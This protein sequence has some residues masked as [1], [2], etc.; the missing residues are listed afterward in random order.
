VLRGIRGVAIATAAHTRRPGRKAGAGD[1]LRTRYLDLGK[2]AL[3]QVSYSR[4]ARGSI[5]P[6]GAEPAN[7][8]PR[9]ARQ[10][11]TRRPQRSRIAFTRIAD[12]WRR[13]RSSRP[14]C[15]AERTASTAADS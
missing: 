8:A 6:G 5:L 13:A 10:G 12:S 4:S 9:G 14:D 15:T 2:V 1:G 7:H 11:M 3:Y